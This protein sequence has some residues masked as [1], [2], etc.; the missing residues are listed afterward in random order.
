M[1]AEP[2][3]PL[4]RDGWAIFSGR[5]KPSSEPKSRRD[6]YRVTL[7][8]CPQCGA[9]LQHVA[10]A[11]EVTCPYCGYRL[12]FEATDLISKRAKLVG[13]LRLRRRYEGHVWEAVQRILRCV[14]CGAQLALSEQLAQRCPYCESTH[15]LV[16]DSQCDFEQPD[17]LLPFSIGRQEAAEA[18][19]HATRSRLLV[20]RRARAVPPE[21]ALQDMFLPFWAYDGFV[22]MKLLGTSVWAPRDPK[23]KLIDSQTMMFENL[24]LP[25]VGTLARDLLEQLLPYDYGALVPYAPL[26]IADRAVAL[27]SL[28]VEHWLEEVYTA[29]EE[30][31]RE[32][33][34]RWAYEEEQRSRR[35]E[36]E[37]PQWVNTRRAYQVSGVSY[38]LLLLPAWIGRMERDGQ[39]R[40]SL[41]NGQTGAVTFG[42]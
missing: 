35:S 32:K 15:V 40:I 36:D 37:P 3:H 26:L 16:E 2:T 38:Q 29:F 1:L 28:D 33:V 22:E 25:A 23:E 17:G 19:G 12:A 31:A 10:G 6:G 42:P 18:I 4:V 13:D 11:G 30:Q 24:L 27:H 41:V 14:S 20:R 39:K 34:L 8:D 5:V 21:N 9:P 7:T